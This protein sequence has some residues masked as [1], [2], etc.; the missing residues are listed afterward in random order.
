MRKT[1]DT[2]I[3]AV[4]KFILATR[5]SGYKGTESAVA[6]L[7]DNSVQAAAR[8]AQ[9]RAAHLA[10]EPVIIL[11]GAR[12]I[13]TGTCCQYRRRPSLIDS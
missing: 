7:V 6:E 13:C 11:T 2:S 8:R 10:A 9:P 3:I 4:D 5:D 1:E 12:P